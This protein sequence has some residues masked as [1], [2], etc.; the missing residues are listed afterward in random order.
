MEIV[1]DCIVDAHRIDRLLDVPKLAGAHHGVE[2]LDRIC[3]ATIEHFT[4][5]AWRRVTE[6]ESNEEAIELRLG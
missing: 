3:A 4:L 5:D 2:L 1:E 6:A